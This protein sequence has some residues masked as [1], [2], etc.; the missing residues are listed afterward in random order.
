MLSCP[1]RTIKLSCPTRMACVLSGRRRNGSLVPTG[2]TYDVNQTTICIQIYQ[3]RSIYCITTYIIVDD[4]LYY[5]IYS[6]IYIHIY[7][8]IYYT[9]INKYIYIYIYMYIMCITTL[10][11]NH[12][13]RDLRPPFPRLL[14]PGLALGLLGQLRAARPPGAGQLLL[15]R[16]R[17]AGL[18]EI[19]G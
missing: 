11:Q 3:M 7:I 1:K 4:Y 15:R 12:L 18:G 5:I 8:Y 19:M 13:P 17:G 10:P 14:H 9:Y 16:Q 6:Y 2:C